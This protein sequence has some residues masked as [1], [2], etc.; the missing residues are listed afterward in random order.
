MDKFVAGRAA[1]QSERSCQLRREV[2]E[3]GH[4]DRLRLAPDRRE[5]R[6]R[7]LH[8]VGNLPALRLEVDPVGHPHDEA[9]RRIE[10]AA[11]HLVTRLV[12]QLARGE[13]VPEVESHRPEQGA[14][15]TSGAPFGDLVATQVALAAVARQ[16]VGADHAEDAEEPQVRRG[17]VALEIALGVGVGHVSERREKG[18]GH[19]C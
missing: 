10:Q 15:T 4:A 16:A 7:I 5:P 17:A 11:P 9:I 12:V 19:V 18:D 1:E 2:H 3:E 8:A 13:Q 6:P 14:H